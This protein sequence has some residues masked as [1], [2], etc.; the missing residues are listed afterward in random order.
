MN[1]Y[2]LMLDYIKLRAW[3]SQVLPSFTQIQ[4]NFSLH[5]VS[6]SPV[7]VQFGPG[8]A[9]FQSSFSSDSVQF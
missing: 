9:Q 3:K 6:F 8:V 7:L 4:S 2:G 5:A 1:E